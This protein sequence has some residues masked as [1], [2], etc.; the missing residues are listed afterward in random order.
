MNDKLTTE[1]E[2]LL[3]S[4]AGD[5][6]VLPVSLVAFITRRS[7][8]A[9]YQWCDSGQVERVGIGGLTCVRLSSLISYL[10]KRRVLPSQAGNVRRVSSLSVSSLP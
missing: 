7:C 6:P 10:E 1:A 5:S 8:K 9:V 4:L 3:R 2:A